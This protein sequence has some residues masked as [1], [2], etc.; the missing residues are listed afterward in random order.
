MLSFLGRI[1]KWLIVTLCVLIPLT[2]LAIVQFSPNVTPQPV[3]QLHLASNVPNL[4]SQAKQLLRRAQR[5]QQIKVNASQLTGLS[6]FVQRAKQPV[7]AQFHLSEQHASLHATLQIREYPLF[8]NVSA[9]VEQGPGVQL[10]NVKVGYL[11]IPDALARYL[12]IH[13]GDQLA[14]LTITERVLARVNHIDI[15]P[16]EIRIT[17]APVADLI[18]ELK[19]RV[20]VLDDEQRELRDLTSA[21]LQFLT[22]L[23]V[24]AQTP[25]TPS[26]IDYL[27]PL[28]AQVSKVAL[29]DQRAEHNK[30]AILA[31][32]IFAGSQ[33]FSR[34]V[35]GMDARLLQQARVP[36]RLH[37]RQRHDLYLH[38]IFSAALE[39]LSNQQTTFAIGEFK[40]FMDKSLS[41][42]GFSFADLAA[43][44][45]GAYFAR[46]AISQTH[47]T[48]ITERLSLL[49][50]E[51]MLMPQIDDLPENLSAAEFERQIGAIDGPVYQGLTEQIKQRIRA[52]PLFDFNAIQGTP[53]C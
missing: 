50:R 36:H 16:D 20:T 39:I 40:E 41:G 19:T 7:S 47:A 37:L 52:L 10:S 15:D 9:S 2:L 14:D 34:F 48:V 51:P 42:S 13:L 26:A 46:C 6:A 24:S 25:M 1:L 49:Y 28:F 8:I 53:V 45:T 18:T 4:V 43:D 17:L 35:G 22:N 3:E 12:I 5:Q 44:M 30:A 11:P 33:H 27:R 21:Y 32:A 29:P 31:M 23:R 38:F